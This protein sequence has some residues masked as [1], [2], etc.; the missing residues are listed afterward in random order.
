MR[1]FLLDTN[2]VGRLVR[3][4]PSIIKKVQ[5][6]PSDSQIRICTITLGE[7]EAGH[8]MTRTTNQRRRDEFTA[9]VNEKF[10]PHALPVSVSTRLYYAQIIE[11]IWRQSPPADRSKRT[12]RHLVDLGVDVNDVW[13]VAVAWEHGLVLVTQDNMRCIRGVVPEVGMENWS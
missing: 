11:R 9:Y 13:I 10:L 3:E 12:E 8:R 1:G 6:L 7:I 4:E 2:H 5:S